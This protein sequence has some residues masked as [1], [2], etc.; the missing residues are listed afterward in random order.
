MFQG[1]KTREKARAGDENAGAAGGSHLCREPQTGKQAP[2]PPFNCCSGEPRHRLHGGKA[3]GGGG[4]VQGG[5]RET[6]QER[7]GWS[8]PTKDPSQSRGTQFLPRKSR[9]TSQGTGWKAP[10]LSHLEADLTERSSLS[11]ESIS[12]DEEEASRPSGSFPAPT[13]MVPGASRFFP[14]QGGQC[15]R[16]TTVRS[17]R[18]EHGKAWVRP[19]L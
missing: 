19:W 16:S 17:F 1:P 5:P 10:S 4:P 13:P 9:F 15:G 18:P 14:A 12:H 6:S 8:Q 3:R 11:Q 2:P 7:W